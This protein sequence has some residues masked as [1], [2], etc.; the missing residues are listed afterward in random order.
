MKISYDQE[1]DS[2]YIRLVDAYHE[3]RTLRLSEDIALNIGAG[4]VLVGVEILG[5]KEVLGSG[6]LPEIVLEN[7]PFQVIS[8]AA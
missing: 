8:T 4:E 2:L 6:Q 7:I 1:T 5:A 3:C